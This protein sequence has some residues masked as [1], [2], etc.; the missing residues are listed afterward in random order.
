MYG[1]TV[2]IERQDLISA[3]SNFIYIY[4][5]I[6]TFHDEIIDFAK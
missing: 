3:T 2:K 6:F 1:E 4:I 5:Y